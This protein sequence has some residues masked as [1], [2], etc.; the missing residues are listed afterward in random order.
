MSDA[1][2]AIFTKP[3]TEWTEEEVAEVKTSVEAFKEAVN[4][5]CRAHGFAYQSILSVTKEGV[6]P[7]LDVVR[8]K[9]EEASK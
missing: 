5:V 8:I 9:E 7:V 4:E 3:Q 2:K 1:L 6:V